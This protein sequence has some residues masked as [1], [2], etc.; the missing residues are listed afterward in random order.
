MTL[1][2][3]NEKFL[4]KDILSNTQYPRPEILIGSLLQ[5][6]YMKKTSVPLLL[7]NSCTKTYHP[8]LDAKDNFTKIIEDEIIREHRYKSLKLFS[9]T[10]TYF[11]MLNTIGETLAVFYIFDGI[12]RTYARLI[13]SNTITFLNLLKIVVATLD[14]NSSKELLNSNSSLVQSFTSNIYNPFHRLCFKKDIVENNSLITKVIEEFHFKQRE[15]DW[16]P[17][18]RLHPYNY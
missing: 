14:K 17:I 9:V 8:V 18:G 11:Y 5:K 15:W 12:H 10:N 13:I 6:F 2:N 16:F 4:V 1:V 7:Y 3:I